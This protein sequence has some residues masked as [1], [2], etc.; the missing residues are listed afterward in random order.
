MTAFKRIAILAALLLIS[1][2]LTAP[3]SHALSGKCT[4][5][6]AAVEGVR[7]TCVAK[8]WQVAKLQGTL[9]VLAASSLTDVAPDLKRAFKRIY[10][11]ADLIFSFGGSGTLAQQAINGVPADLFLSAGPAPMKLVAEKNALA[12]FARDFATNSLVIAVLKENRLKISS[13]SD[14]SRSKIAICAPEVPCGVLAQSVARAAKVSLKPVTLELNVK[15]VEAKILLGEVDAGLIYRTDVLSSSE[16]LAIEIPEA[17]NLKTIY[18]IAPLP[19]S[20]SNIYTRDAF[21]DFLLSSKGKALL[22]KAGFA[23]P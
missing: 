7:Y 22:S 5:G 9:V 19:S 4:S 21:I 1:G 12:G 11:G 16:L 20:K 8:K 23:Q 3:S 6:F 15:S 14:F 10:P 2:A 13:L 18:S 17:V